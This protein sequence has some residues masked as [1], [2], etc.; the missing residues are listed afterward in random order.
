MKES[1]TELKT[2]LDDVIAKIQDPSTDLDQALVL[3]AEGKKLVDKLE[4][5]LGEVKEKITKTKKAD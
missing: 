5:Y 3:H 2:K 1:Y 4:K